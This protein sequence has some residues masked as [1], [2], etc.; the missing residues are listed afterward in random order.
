MVGL[1]AS[2]SDEKGYV[3]ECFWRECEL[4]KQGEWGSKVAHHFVVGERKTFCQTLS[5]YEALRMF[6]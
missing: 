3:T 1:E 2:T 4:H 6:R 5:V